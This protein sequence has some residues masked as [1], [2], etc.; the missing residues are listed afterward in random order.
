MELKQIQRF[1]RFKLT[2][3]RWISVCAILGLFLSGIHISKAQNTIPS[4]AILN[5]HQGYLIVR[6]PM[7]T[8]KIDTLNAMLARTKDES[9]KKKLEKI[10]E[11]TKEERD[12]FFNQ[13]VRA[14]RNN[15]TFSKS[16]YFFDTDARDLNTASYYNMDG[17]RISVGDLSESNLFYLYFERTEDSK[18]DAMVIYDRMQNKV[19]APF[20]NNFAQSGLNLIIV[21]ISEKKFPEWRVGKMNKRLWKYLN[22]VKMDSE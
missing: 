19:R 6:F 11:D 21:K 15:Y 13:Y 16:A 5:L 14:F 12:T 22:E 20:P 1:I 7:H 3:S 9:T 2:T 8:S 4:V 10:L 17:E 18:I